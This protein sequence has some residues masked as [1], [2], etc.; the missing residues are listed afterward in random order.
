MTDAPLQFKSWWE[1]PDGLES[2]SVGSRKKGIL[3]HYD[4]DK[5][6]LEAFKAKID[7]RCYAAAQGYQLD[8][9]ASWRGT[10]VMRH[11]VN[12]DKIIVKRDTD[13]HYVFFS[14]R[15]DRDNGTII[16]FVKNRQGKSFGAVR[17]E[18]RPWVGMPPVPVP[19]FPS[20]PTT[21]KDRMKV[22]AAY[23]RMHDASNGHAYL[24]KERAIPPALLKDDRFIGRIRIDH[25]SN[26]V[27]PHFDDKGLSGYELRNSNYKGFASGGS[28]SLWL[29]NEFPTD[30]RIVFCESA[31][32]CLSHAVLFPDNRARY[33]SIG[34]KT[35]PQQ[36]ELIRAA[37]ARMPADSEVISGMNADAEGAKL[38]EVVRNA[39]E[40]SGRHDLRFVAQAPEKLNDWNDQLRANPHPLLSYRPDVPSV[41]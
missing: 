20:L 40:L 28:K 2:S 41:S 19:S 11:P 4:N 21:A 9:K 38:A 26:A 22:E 12:D 1:K 27:F 32:E 36:L 18:L 35:S 6:E 7:L 8:S 34:G 3:M 39:V 10:S 31:I 14:V 30:N 15:N 24:E 13:G 23:A 29:S 37:V 5:G 17:M 25:R 33:A 16:D